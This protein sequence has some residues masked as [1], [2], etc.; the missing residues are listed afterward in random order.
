ML[1]WLVAQ[2]TTDTIEQ[3]SYKD[4]KDHFNTYS[5]VTDKVLERLIEDEG[6]VAGEEM[7][8]GEGRCN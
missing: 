7:E 8:E 5:Q 2:K 1:D 3:V 6:F 4:A